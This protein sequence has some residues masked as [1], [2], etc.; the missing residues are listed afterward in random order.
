MRA[1]RLVSLIRNEIKSIPTRRDTFV[2]LVPTYI[3]TFRTDQ[4]LLERIEKVDWW[5]LNPSFQLSIGS[6]VWYSDNE[7]YMWRCTTCCSRLTGYKNW[8]SKKLCLGPGHWWRSVFHCGG[9]VLPTFHI[10]LHKSIEYICTS[11]YHY[12][13]FNVKFSFDRKFWLMYR[14][15]VHNFELVIN[16]NQTHWNKGHN[17]IDEFLEELPVTSF[18]FFA[19]P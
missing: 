6:W 16:E 17:K 4:H 1:V 2:C 3:C 8:E 7:V 14:Y 11:R 19:R 18:W 9:S 10:S 5:S 12:F 15:W 13:S